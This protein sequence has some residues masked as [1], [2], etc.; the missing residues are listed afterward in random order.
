VCTHWCECT[1]VCVHGLTHEGQNRTL[2][3]FLYYSLPWKRVS[4]GTRTLKLY[5]SLSLP[6][7][8]MPVSQVH[9]GH[10]RLFT[11]MLGIQTWLLMFVQ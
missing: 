5:L 8:P 1:G 9:C 2:D 4:Q 10:S 3:V 11:G 7:I 6:P